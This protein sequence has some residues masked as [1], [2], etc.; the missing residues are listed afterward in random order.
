M[1]SLLGR[2]PPPT[3]HH[4]SRCATKIPSTD[5]LIAS[6]GLAAHCLPVR[7]RSSHPSGTVDPTRPLRTA[8]A[9]TGVTVLTVLSVRTSTSLLPAEVRHGL[10][11][12]VSTSASASALPRTCRT[13]DAVAVS[14]TS[15]TCRPRSQRGDPTPTDRSEIRLTGI[16]RFARLFGTRRVRAML[17]AT[18][19]LR[20]RSARGHALCRRMTIGNVIVATTA[21]RRP[22]ARVRCVRTPAA[23]RRSVRGLRHAMAVR[24]SSPWTVIPHVVA[25]VRD[26]RAIRDRVASDPWSRRRDRDDP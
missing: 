13:R 11:A 19:F 14:T 21:C 3:R 10:S 9:M 15:P 4:R 12:D 26:A 25:T 18:T 6:P 17:P 7:R 8:P 5:L 1:Q 20:R 16:G 23:V 2:R 22:G 24:P